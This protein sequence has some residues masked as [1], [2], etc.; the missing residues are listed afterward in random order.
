MLVCKQVVRVWGRRG[1][2]LACRRVAISPPVPQRPGSMNTIAWHP[3][4][5]L[6]AV[7]GADAV[8][9]I[10]EI[11]RDTLGAAAPLQ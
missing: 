10:Y 2:S 11:D 7:S 9:S 3:Y 4:Q 6:F 5:L 8:V 1:D